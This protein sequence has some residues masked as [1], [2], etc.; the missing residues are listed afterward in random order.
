[1]SKRTKWGFAGACLLA[2]GLFWGCGGTLG[3]S[4]GGESHFLAYCDESCADGL[5]CISGVCTRG[6]VIDEDGCEDLHPDAE[7]SDSIEPG[8]VAVCDVSCTDDEQC[9][10]LGTSYNCVSGQCRNASNLATNGSG[11]TDGGGSGGSGSGVSNT[12]GPATSSTS[13]GGSTSGESTNGGSTGGAGG[14]G[15]S[16][17]FLFQEFPDGTTF[18][19]PSGCDGTCTCTAGELDCQVIEDG[20]CADGVP[21]FPCPAGVQSDPVNV[22]R[23]AFDSGSFLV[24][25]ILVLDVSYSGGCAVHDFGLCY[26]PGVEPSASG[27][28]LEGDLRLIHD[29]HDDMCEAER[30]ETLHFRLDPYA[31]YIMQELDVPNGLVDTAFGLYAFG[32]LTCD[33]TWDAVGT[34]VNQAAEQ[35]L[36]HGCVENIDCARVSSELSC[37]FTSCGEVIALAGEAEFRTSME[38]V[39]ATVCD[40]FSRND[41]PIPSPPLC[42]ELPPIG[43]VDGTCVELEE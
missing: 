4:S 3:S 17:E 16:C 20:I 35:T 13:S 21:V 12:D 37:H 6:C 41:C 32:E 40:E 15:T 10:S 34:L 43:C 23:A 30:N 19:N 14:A 18:D 36:A 38:S 29:S 28:F 5:N 22:E 11:G 25:D 42:G 9:E 26:G 2:L 27:D 33:E 8:A 7:C 24:S 39:E 1:M 31:D